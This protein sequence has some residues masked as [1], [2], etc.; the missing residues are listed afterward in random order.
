MVEFFIRGILGISF[1][2]RLSVALLGVVHCS[3]QRDCP[4]FPAVS[5]TPDASS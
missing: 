5:I 4:D 2:L 3:P 1:A